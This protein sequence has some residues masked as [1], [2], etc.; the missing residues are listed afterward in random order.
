MRDYEKEV[1]MQDIIKAI[2]NIDKKAIQRTDEAKDYLQSLDSQKQTRLTE[3]KNKYEN[4]LSQ[5]LM[6]KKAGLDKEIEM[7]S[8]LIIQEAESQRMA[9]RERFEKFEGRVSEDAFKMI[10]R[11]LEG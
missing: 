1:R 8:Q 6:E 3:L 5:E 4:R 11:N 10:L 7:E 9:V 2:I